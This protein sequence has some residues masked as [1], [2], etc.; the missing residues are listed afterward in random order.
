MFCLIEKSCNKHKNVNFNSL[1]VY[2]SRGSMISTV[3][4]F[5]NNKTIGK[6]QIFQMVLILCH[7]LIKTHAHA[8]LYVSSIRGT[9]SSIVP[10]FY[11]DITIEQ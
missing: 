8:K 10:L 3:P 7:Y 2:T 1:L 6:N 5:H 9:I 4:L 11:Y